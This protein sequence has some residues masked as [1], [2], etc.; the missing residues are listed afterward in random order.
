MV[1]STK[2]ISHIYNNKKIMKIITCEQ[3]GGPCDYKM[4]ANTPEEL[5]KG[6]MRH[7]EETHPEMAEK[8]EN[9]SY[10]ETK[11]WNHFFMK[12]WR[13]APNIKKYA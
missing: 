1:D 10:E 2:S 3:L 5:I 11:N 8:M 13:M 7:L 6:G 9:M 12:L 4:S